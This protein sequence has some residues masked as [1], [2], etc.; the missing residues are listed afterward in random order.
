[1]HSAWA[2]TSSLKCLLIAWGLRRSTDFLRKD[3]K[4]SLMSDSAKKTSD[5]RWLEVYQHINVTI[6]ARRAVDIRTKNGYRPYNCYVRTIFKRP[7][8]LLFNFL[9]IYNIRRIAGYALRTI[10]PFF[11]SPLSGSSAISLIHCNYMPSCRFRQNHFNL[12]RQKRR[13]DLQLIFYKRMCYI[14][15]SLGA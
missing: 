6:F 15:P 12:R 7:Q 5:R 8:Q 2:R 1:M 10:N 14:K 4:L 11:S 3:S 9:L 13:P